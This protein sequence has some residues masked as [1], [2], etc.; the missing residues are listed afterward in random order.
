MEFEK[1]R[2]W[3]KRSALIKRRDGYECQRCKRF[4]RHIAAEHV[5]HIL[6]I[7]YYPEY[8][9]EGWN[10]ISLCKNCHNKMHDRDS[11]ELTEEG[12]NLARETAR[13]QGIPWMR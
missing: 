7:E 1:T 2:T 4:G 12:N 9:L 11:H 6:P 3:R 10:L 13:R 8:R 5:H